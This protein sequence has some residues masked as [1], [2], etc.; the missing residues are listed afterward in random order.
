MTKFVKTLA[1]MFAITFLAYP[2]SAKVVHLNDVNNLMFMGS[3]NMLDLECDS[4]LNQYKTQQANANCVKLPNGCLQCSCDEDKY[5]YTCK[6]THPGAFVGV[7]DSCDIDG[8]P[9]YEKCKCNTEQ[10]FLSLP[11]IRERYMPYV[12]GHGVTNIA[13]VFNFGSSL[14]YMHSPDD[15][16]YDVTCYKTYKHCK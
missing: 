11:E 16:S 15:T 2:S 5:K 8:E 1:F 3:D 13:Q 10:R 4:S 6:E 9:K 14:T 12:R 7:G